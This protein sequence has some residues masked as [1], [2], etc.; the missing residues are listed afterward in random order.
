M[1]ELADAKV[2]KIQQGFQQ[3]RRN[4]AFTPVPNNQSR[5]ERQREEGQSRLGRECVQREATG[6][7]KP[8]ASCQP[9][10]LDI[11]L[12]SMSVLKF[13]CQEDVLLTNGFA[14]PV[15]SDDLSH[16][17]EMTVEHALR[18]IHA[19]DRTTLVRIRD[20]LGHFPSVRGYP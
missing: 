3:C 7:W 1:V 6:K 19:T 12:A 13:E 11:H 10:N 4:V 15:H 16:R 2:R 8:N 17:I 14:A 5:I 9:S 20:L 18:D